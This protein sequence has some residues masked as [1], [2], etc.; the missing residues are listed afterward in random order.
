MVGVVVVVVV[1]DGAQQQHDDEGCVGL[2]L[3]PSH[4]Q[5]IAHGNETAI[6]AMSSEEDVLPSLVA[7]DLDDTIW[8]PE[9]WLCSRGPFKKDARTGVVRCRGG[10]K[11]KFLGDSA[12][13]LSDL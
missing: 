5:T 9:M 1:V 2:H 13:I 3:E 10:E 4:H 12:A 7:F 6:M 11:M 8:S